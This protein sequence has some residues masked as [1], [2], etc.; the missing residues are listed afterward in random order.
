MKLAN[1]SRSYPIHNRY[2][3]YC[4]MSVP[5]DLIATIGNT[6]LR[7]STKTVYLGLGILTE[8]VKETEPTYETSEC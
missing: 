8:C 4:R 7:Y 1:H 6:E 5:Q 3:D 2:A